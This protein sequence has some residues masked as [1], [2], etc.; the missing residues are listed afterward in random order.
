MP[1]THAARAFSVSVSA[2][3]MLCSRA[4]AACCFA[5]ALALS[6]SALARACITSRDF[7]FNSALA[8]VC[9]AAHASNPPKP[10]RKAQLEKVLLSKSYPEALKQITASYQHVWHLPPRATMDNVLRAG[11]TAADSAE[12]R[13]N[14]YSACILMARTILE[15][16][17][18][19][20]ISRSAAGIVC[21]LAAA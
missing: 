14:I 16:A 12:A 15:K 10:T 21:A 1:P 4:S 17:A 6:L 20:E 3:F 18:A 5:A 8:A 2:A 13:L 9:G 7:F 11:P 19:E